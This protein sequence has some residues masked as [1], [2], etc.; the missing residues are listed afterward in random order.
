MKIAYF[1]PLSPLKSGIVDF[2]EKEILPYLRKYGEIDIFIDDGYRPSNKEII[3]E[4][5][6]Y[7][8][9]K[10][11]KKANEYDITFYNIGNNPQHIYIYK[12]LQKY[13]G[14]VILHDVFIHGLIWNM[15]LAKGDKEGY[16]E[17]FLYSHGKEGEKIASLAIEGKKT[18]FEIDFKYPL[19]TKIVDNCLG[20]IVHSGFAKNVVVN[21]TQDV[22]IRKINQPLTPNKT[23]T[24]RSDLREKMGLRDETLI[25]S[26]FGFISAHKRMNT[27]LEVFEK[28]HEECQDSILLI[29]GKDHI[30]L[31]NMVKNLKIKNSVIHTGFVPFDRL[32]EYMQISDICINLRYPTA[33]ETSRSVLDLMSMG[34]PVIVSNVGWFS[35]LPDNCCARADVDSYE[36][37]LL[38]HYLRALAGNEKL[39]RKMGENARE[40]VI[41]THNPQKIANEYLEFI[42][43]IIDGTNQNDNRNI[44]NSVN[45]GV[46]DD[47]LITGWVE[48]SL[49]YG[50]NIVYSTE[51]ASLFIKKREGDNIWW[52]RCK[53][54]ANKS[55]E[56]IFKKDDIEKK[57]FV[58]LKR[59]MNTF[60][61]ECNLKPGV[62]KVYFVGNKLNR[63][64]TIN[65]HINV[66]FGLKEFRF[67]NIYAPT[68]WGGVA[69]KKR[70]CV[71][72][73][74]VP[75]ERG[76]NE[77]LADFLVQK[78]NKYGYDA[79]MF[80]T[81]QNRHYIFRKLIAGYL[82]NR[83]IDL[84]E[85]NAKQ[86]HQIISL[87]YPSFAI[88]HPNH[89]CWFNHRQREY[90]DL[91]DEWI[92]NETRR[93]KII[94]LKRRLER[95][96]IHKLDSYLLKKNVPLIYSQSKNIKGRLLKWGNIPTEVLYPPPLKNEECY[97]ESYD[98]YIFTISRLS[99]LKRL[100]LL[101][102]AFKYVKNKDIKCYI[103]GK[104][105]DYHL[106]N[107]LI[108]KNKLKDRVK[109][110]GFLSDEDALKYYANSRA[111]FFGPL[112]EDY[113]LVSLEAMKSKK[114][115]IT[116]EDSGGPTEFVI[117]GKTGFIA[118]ADPLDIAQKIDIIAD[119]EEKAKE[120]GYAAYESV[121]DITW[122]N[123][124]KK[125]IIV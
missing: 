123:T 81:P 89:V 97:C 7:N 99:K 17:E 114:A 19:I 64:G 110:L 14:I 124:I 117:D 105:E 91:W 32:Y 104:G 23:D 79:F 18:F 27:I 49:S 29:V 96:I 101:I 87:K 119:E 121:K 68:T 39:R 50:K 11:P 74:Q 82:S 103:A 109:L 4:F 44:D 107:D 21:Q 37:E 115:L 38:L 22:K 60:Q 67:D 6:I 34:K 94:G 106:L 46:D 58:N 13:Q 83:L 98:N 45:I 75:F 122:E 57:Y 25:I 102:T 12:T 40:Y 2:S 59:G 10:F 78:L 33:G 116:C 84:D 71:V 9:K 53:S 35:E 65:H 66:C 93:F 86:I 3:S 20:I 16:I 70:I 54:P 85:Y 51:T 95:V 55:I 47:H 41:K 92:K 73:S 112:N 31:E 120:M 80:Y 125:L 43:E 111:V 36:K 108:E 30:D 5:R 52:M 63:I 62:Y 76:G 28:F 69:E 42:H 77:Y 72:T 100:D 8:Y 1:S 56:V 48:P 118:K 24:N 88:K 90:Y 61:Q 26:S 15:T 113:G